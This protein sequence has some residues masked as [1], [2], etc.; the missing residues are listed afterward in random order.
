MKREMFK[1]HTLLFL[2][3][4]S[5]A[6]ALGQTGIN[7][8]GSV[9]DGSAV[10]DVKS[11]NMGLL[12][13]RLTSLQRD[14]ISNPAIGLIIYNTTTHQL[15]IFNGSI[16]GPLGGTFSCGSSQVSDLN[17][18]TYN[19]IQIGDQCWM[20]SNLNTGTRIDGVDNPVNDSIIE[21]YCPEDN[22][23]SC[24]VHGGQYTWNEM[25]YYATKENTQ[26]ICPV[27]WRIP[28][29][30][31]WCLLEQEVDPA[32]SCE[33]TGWRGTDGGTKLKKG[34]TSGFDALLS[35]FRD[36]DGSYGTGGHYW[37]SG[38]ETTDAWNRGF[39]ESLAGVARNTRDKEHG[40]SI[41]CIKNEN[42]LPILN[43]DSVSDISVNSATA[44]GFII[45]LGSD[46]VVNYGHC[47][48]E[49]PHP[50]V[51]F[52][53]TDLGSVDTTGAFSSNLSNLDLS[54]T[55][56]V[57]AYAG[58]SA[59]VDYSSET[60]FVTASSSGNLPCQGVSSV[61]YGGEIY[62]TIRIGDQCWLDRNL[63]IGSMITTGTDQT[64]NEIIEKYCFLD[65]IAKCSVYGGWYQWDETM[66]YVTT[67]G[68][69]GI[70]PPGFHIPTETEWCILVDYVDSGTV[71]CGESGSD[72][73]GKLKET[74]FDH[75]F[76]PNIG[77]TDASGFTAIPAGTWLGWGGSFG[78]YR[79]N[80]RIWS[81]CQMDATYAYARLL[82]NED[83]NVD[84]MGNE[85]IN[86]NSVRCIKDGN[87]VNLPPGIPYYPEPDS[88]STDIFVDT[89]LAWSCT[90]P[91]GDSLVYDVYF[92][93][94]ADP[95][96]VASG[97]TDTS[98][99]LEDS[100]LFNVEYFW[101]IVA[102][103]IYSLSTEGNVWSFTSEDGNNPPGT[104]FNPKP[105]DEDT[106]FVVDTT[107]T[108]SCTDLEGDPLTYDVYF[109]RA[110][111]PPLVVSGQADTNYD[112]GTLQ[113]D[114][115]YFWK[116]IAHDD[117]ANSTAGP[118]WSF[119]T[120]DGNDPPA[121]PIAVYPANGATDVPL[122]T[123]LRW[124]CIDPDS[125]PLT[126]TVYFG[127]VTD[128]PQVVASQ[129]DTTYD[130]GTLSYGL[131]YYWKI[132]AHD[133]HANSTTGSIWNFTTDIGQTCPGI[134]TVTYDGQV[135]NTVQIGTMCWLR[136]SLN[137]GTRKDG[138]V[139]QSDNDTIDKYCYNDLESNCDIYGGMY[140][141][142]EMMDYVTTQGAQGICPTGWHIPTD[143]EWKTLEGTVDNTFGVGDP[144][145]NILGWRG[146]DAGG[147]L[148]DT[149]TTHWNAPN[150]GATNG[151]GFTGLPGGYFVSSNT[152]YYYIN[153]FVFL[154]TSDDSGSGTAWYR[155]LRYN[156]VTVYR[157]SN[158]LH[159]NALYVRCLKDE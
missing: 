121:A 7:N 131:T 78:F 103:D 140:Q 36:T 70:C 126:Y 32:I 10:L 48:S 45:D 19:T 28:N 155:G 25:M 149:T 137:V 118:V 43:L 147:E 123:L 92:G 96:Q 34:G 12:P 89:A 150:T 141:W 94:D 114:S 47:W 69:R 30:R 40:Y 56:Y 134:P 93:V 26:G 113:Y 27:G 63:N 44:Y 68:V 158:M 51:Q 124:S 13:P 65:D 104:P 110:T 95:P 41:R 90:D 16:W 9:P 142:D 64:D 35:G 106:I 20:A 119:T 156:D 1:S 100:L 79:A 146:G 98:Y 53:H 122:D 85:K 115:T 159:E 59:G 39:N 157:H 67:E 129:T 88:G 87:P 132:V 61:L 148:K 77:A 73:G 17:G 6:F 33:S 120:D 151:S 75:W 14:S 130:P 29:D 3:V 5:V 15:E 107:L 49:Y 105:G 55:Y 71:P 133:D 127:T 86:A 128:P 152:T 57:K 22:E 18:N 72:A 11:S 60:S 31:D 38:S 97:I 8:D 108:W 42:S 139:M 83:A 74:G 117:H 52:N 111:D 154:W 62:E 145:W 21:K 37:T 153:D 82:H 112:P 46:S 99:S 125:D 116:I 101:K 81:S 138:S 136:E 135:Y 66:Q 2:F 91:D 54:T 143:E 58:S 23:D 4:C 76:A 102:T 144:E 84:L 80:A 50:T 24:H 109:G